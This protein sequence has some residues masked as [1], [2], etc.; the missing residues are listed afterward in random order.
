MLARVLPLGAFLLAIAAG[1][2]P[3]QLISIRTV[4][5]S[6]S[7]QFD[8]FPS[9]RMGMGGVSIAVDDSLHDPFSNPAK[10]VRLGASSFFGSPGLYSVSQ[11]PG[12]AG[13]CRRGLVRSGDWFGGAAVAVQQIDLSE[14]ISVLPPSAAGLSPLRCRGAPR[15]GARN[16]AQPRQCVRIRDARHDA[17]GAGPLVG[18]SMEWSGLHGVDGVDLLY[19]RSAGSPRGP[20]DRRA[21][22]RPQAVGRG[23][24]PERRAG[25]QTGSRPRTK[26]LRRL[27][28][29][30]RPPGL[31]P[32]TPDGR[33]PRPD[34]QSGAPSSSTP[35][36]TIAGMAAGG[37]WRRPT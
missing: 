36:A 10:G 3:A 9:L 2:V 11:G 7:H 1:P 8:L 33:E 16:R 14:S 37:G 26:F 27:L 32:A 21:A 19:P 24:G 35:A 15:P 5:I 28:L 4:P 29:G 34:Q 20:R 18:A 6:Q 25:A 17:A 30:S 13:P 22:R 31:R 23:T 12:P